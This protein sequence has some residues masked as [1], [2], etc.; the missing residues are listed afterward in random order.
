VSE[1]KPDC[2]ETQDHD[3]PI[4]CIVTDRP[5]P[6][7]K[8]PS[9]A[10]CN[11]PVC[12][13][14]H[15]AP[16][17]NEGVKPCDR[18]AIEDLVGSHSRPVG[19]PLDSESGGDR[20]SSIDS[21]QP[22][23]PASKPRCTCHDPGAK[24]CPADHSLR[25][26]PAKPTASEGWEVVL[27]WCEKCNQSI[28]VL[29]PEKVCTICSNPPSPLIRQSDAQNQIDAWQAKSDAQY[30]LQTELQRKLIEA[31]ARVKRK[32]EIAMVVGADKAEKKFRTLVEGVRKIH[33]RLLGVTDD[34]ELEYCLDELRTL[35]DSEVKE[36]EDGK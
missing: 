22:D 24:S 36:K 8:G 6:K 23:R 25:V 27:W 21:L 9:G 1:C 34:K 11:E 15:H 5:D 26:P 29:R 32:L 3:R 31:E 4:D 35:L 20:E 17:E 12:P 7:A 33:K 2:I 18:P 30:E 14:N 16:V 10:F 28:Y 19:G 13:G